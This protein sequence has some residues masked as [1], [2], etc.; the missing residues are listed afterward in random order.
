MREKFEGIFPYLVS[1]VD[2]QGNVKEGELARLVDHLIACGVH[3]L[4]PLGSTGEFYY[5]S[6]EQKMQIVQTVVRAADHRVPVVAGVASSS[7]REAVAQ[8]KA[9]AQMGVDGILGILNV[10]FPLGQ[11]Q[12]YQYYRDLALATELPVVI[13]N[14]PRF[15]GFEISVDTLLRLS[16][17]P[18]VQYYKDASF[19]TGR[20]LS[21]I[22][23]VGE[24]LRIFSA[25]AHVPAFV[26]EMG[27][28]GWMSGPACLIPRES[29]RLYQLCREKR[30][31]EAMVLQKKLWEINT[32]F[33][34]Y[35]L[36]ACVKAGLELQGFDMGAPIAP[37]PRLDETGVAAVKAA[38]EKMAELEQSLEAGHGK[39][40]NSDF[41]PI[42][43]GR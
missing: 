33:Q 18:T 37:T 3:G 10:Y 5:L 24:E 42:G 39:G 35:N 21:I 7:T 14:N 27:G 40:R 12:V 17:L 31:E 25:S 29:V 6:W 22:S 28:V 41:G 8:A 4:T 23:Q 26:M 19:N 36:A 13:Y 9:F 32:L 20:L 15:S 43:E 2:D 38:L 16:K 11:E 34:K 30:W 1:P